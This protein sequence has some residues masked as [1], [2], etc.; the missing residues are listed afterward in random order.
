MALPITIA[1][2]QSEL[3]PGLFAV[4]SDTNI[5]GEQWRGI[6]TEHTSEKEAEYTTEMQLLGPAGPKSEAGPI[7]YG[8]MQEWVRNRFVHKY[9]GIGFV[10]TRQAILDNLY[11]DRFPQALTALKDAHRQVK[12]VLAMSVFNNGFNTAYPLGD[13]QPYFSTQHPVSTGVV[14]NTPG[15]V[16]Q[17][18]EVALQDAVL[19][20]QYFL[21]ASGLRN[22][23][24]PDKV[25]VPANL[26]FS[27]DRILDS[28]Y[29]TGTANNDINAIV[30][31]GMF[32]GGYSIN[33]FLTSPYNWFV[34]TDQKKGLKYFE[35]EPLEVNMFPDINTWNI[36]VTS[37]TRYSFG[38]DNFR[39]GVGVLGA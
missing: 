5:Y 37:L 30:N 39:T 28:K 34:L 10:I 3:R 25:L 12:N 9:Y 32:P 31:M 6:F 36:N 26:Q 22:A 13:G 4:M 35:R 11:K 38:C 29:Q 33:Q 20:V 7:P 14:S 27:I 17:L 24:K 1:Q 19:L 8:T 23:Y 2:I 16:T 21:S 18:S 15:V